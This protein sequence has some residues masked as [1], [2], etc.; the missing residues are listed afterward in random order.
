MGAVGQLGVDEG[1][2]LLVLNEVGQPGDG[3]HDEWAQRAFEMQGGHPGQ[4]IT[5]GHRDAHLARGPAVTDIERGGHLGGLRHPRIK[6]PQRALV[7]VFDARRP[8]AIAANGRALAAASARAP[9]S[10]AAIS[11]ASPTAAN[12][13]SNIRASLVK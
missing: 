8:P 4:P 6:R 13:E 3:R 10:I 5:Q 2:R 11:S 7:V 1:Q 9:S 12:S